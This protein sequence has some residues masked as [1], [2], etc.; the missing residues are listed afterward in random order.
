MRWTP[1][2]DADAPADLPEGNALTIDG[3]AAA[4]SAKLERITE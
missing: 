1:A 4:T 2:P 3:Q